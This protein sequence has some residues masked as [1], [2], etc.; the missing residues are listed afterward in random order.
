MHGLGRFFD[1]RLNDAAQFPIAAKN[2]F[3]DLPHISPD[4]DQITS[5]LG[6]LQF[7]QLAIPAPPP[8]NDGPVLTLDVGLSVEERDVSSDAEQ[9]VPVDRLCRRRARGGRPRR[10]AGVDAGRSPGELF[11][12]AG[13]PRLN[14]GNPELQL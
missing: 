7:Y 3:G 12:S 14:G 4:N 1:P 13:V 8:P 2:G 5:K 9:T 6:A 11:L 10:R